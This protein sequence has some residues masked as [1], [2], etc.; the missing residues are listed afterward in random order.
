VTFIHAP[1]EPLLIISHILLKYG[2]FVA[3]LGKGF[4]PSYSPGWPRFGCPFWGLT[5]MCVICGPGVEKGGEGL[6][7]GGKLLL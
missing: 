3:A 2:D 7:K 1:N 5:V 4:D 6:E